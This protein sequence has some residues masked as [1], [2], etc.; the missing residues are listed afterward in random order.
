MG[1]ATIRLSETMEMCLPHTVITMT[2]TKTRRTTICNDEAS[3]YALLLPIMYYYILKKIKFHL[4][5][6]DSIHDGLA[7]GLFRGQQGLSFIFLIFSGEFLGWPWDSIIF[8][9]H[10]CCCCLRRMEQRVSTSGICHGQF[11]HQ[12]GI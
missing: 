5:D 1:Q 8:L 6:S 2:T 7:V 11:F 10:F 12:R 4:F 3:N 9:D